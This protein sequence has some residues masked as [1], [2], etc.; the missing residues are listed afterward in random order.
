MKKRIRSDD[1]DDDGSVLGNG[2]DYEET[3]YTD[4]VY[5]TDFKVEV[6]GIDGMKADV[7]VTYGVNS[8][9]DPSIRP[10]PAPPYQGPG[11]EIR[12]MRN[13]ADPSWH[14]VPWAGNS[15]T[16]VAKV[17]NNGTLDAPG[18]NKRFKL[19]F[20]YVGKRNSKTGHVTEEQDERFI[21]LPNN[22][23]F[24]S[25]IEEDLNNE[26]ATC[27]YRIMTLIPDDHSSHT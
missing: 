26:L 17:K 11:I 12:N 18:E 3:D 5:P 6:N 21:K 23:R 15:N 19:M 20:E 16:V 25:F 9:P 27:I 8:K 13:M 7:H 1:A 14:N 10:W 4:P 2:E 24:T 22:I